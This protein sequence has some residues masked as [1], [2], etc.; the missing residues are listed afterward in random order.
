MKPLA[1][2]L[3][4]LWQ[5][6]WQ[7][8]SRQMLLV[9]GQAFFYR[10]LLLPMVGDDYSYAFIWDGADTGNLLD[11]V[12]T[13]QRITSFSDIIASQLPHYNAFS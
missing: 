5:V 8:L 4:G 3:Y 1:D 13:R 7:R 9:F 6:F 12:G 10:N 11:G 2:R